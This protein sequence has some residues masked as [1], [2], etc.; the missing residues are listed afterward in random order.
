VSQVGMAR[1]PDGVTAWEHHPANPLLIPGPL[2]S[3]D[4]GMVYKPTALWDERKQRWDLWFNAS[5]VLNSFERIGHAW[6][7]RL[8]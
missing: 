7:D 5:Q 4:A 3:W 8:W 6:S 1:S 2:G